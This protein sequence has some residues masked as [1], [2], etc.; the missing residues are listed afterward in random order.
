M[1]P[2]LVKFRADYSD[3]I[4]IKSYDLSKDGKVGRNYPVQMLPTQFF[5]SPDG[6]PYVPKDSTGRSYELVTNDAGEHTLTKHAG[7][8]SYDDM[9]SIYNDLISR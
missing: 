5:F 9:V 2:E 3:K 8:L 4:I 7:V 1:A 6:T